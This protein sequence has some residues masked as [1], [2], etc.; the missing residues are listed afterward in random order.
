VPIIG[1]SPKSIELA[2]DRKFFSA[3]LDKLKIRPFEYKMHIKKVMDNGAIYAPAVLNIRLEDVLEAFTRSAQNVTALS[4]GSGY[5]T[6]AS[7][8]HVVLNGFKNLVTLSFGSGFSIPQ[9]EKMLSAAANRPAASSG[10][11][12]APAKVVEAAKAPEPEPE[13]DVDMG[14]LFGY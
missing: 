12:N 8:H 9:A 1:T 5:V 2:E 14:D 13:V 11:A 4:L 6:S 3:L 7:A 10:P